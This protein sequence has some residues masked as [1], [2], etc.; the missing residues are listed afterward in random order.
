VLITSDHPFRE[1][2]LLDGKSDPR[3]PWI[4]KFP[5]QQQGVVYSRQFNA[6]LTQDLLL[7]ALRNE[8]GDAAGAALWLD[9]K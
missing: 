9:K 3:I 4:L 6:V 8:L 2:E 1:A 5:R 7:A